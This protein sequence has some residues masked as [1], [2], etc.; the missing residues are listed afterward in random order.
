VLVL[1]VVAR[2]SAVGFWGWAYGA[3]SCCDCRL[4]DDV[5]VGDGVIMVPKLDL[6]LVCVKSHSPRWN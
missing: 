2:S 3:S 4:P 1:V 5:K 6:H